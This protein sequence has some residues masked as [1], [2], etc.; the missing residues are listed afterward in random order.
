MTTFGDAFCFQLV[1]E[2]HG[3]DCREIPCT[4][5]A[6]VEG[7]SA[8]VLCA[9]VS[10]APGWLEKPYTTISLESEG[11]QHLSFTT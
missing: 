8:A 1:A 7:R 4:E 5:A 6:C 11:A 10:R 2:V 3:S 9:A